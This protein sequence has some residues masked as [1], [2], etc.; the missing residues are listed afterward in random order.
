MTL[1]MERTNSVTTAR[2]FLVRLSSPYV[3]NGIKGIRK[4]VREEARRLLK[5]FPTTVDIAQASDQCP[6][7]FGQPPRSSE[8]G[9]VWVDPPS[10]H[11]YGFPKLWDRKT[12]CREW[13]IA[14][15]YPKHLAEQ[16]LPVRF[17][18]ASPEDLTRCKNT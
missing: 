1:P 18:E 2:D 4:E 11:R 14:N 6:H 9:P 3:E 7:V 15:G 12:E 8:S 16:G 13:M 5:H 17:I 10:G